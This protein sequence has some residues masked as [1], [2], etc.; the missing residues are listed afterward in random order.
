MRENGTKLIQ[1]LFSSQIVD[2]VKLVHEWMN[3][4]NGSDLKSGLS[5]RGPR[6]EETQR[7]EVWR[8]ERLLML[9]L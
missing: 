3:V 2:R 1:S 6:Q 5:K 4:C 7:L 9:R 8:L